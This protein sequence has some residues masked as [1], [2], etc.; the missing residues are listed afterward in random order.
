MTSKS[1][2][3]DATDQE[4]GPPSEEVSISMAGLS[5]GEREII[6][7]QL[8]APELTIGYFALFRY[9]NMN[10]AII[11]VIALAA[12]I[13]AGATMPLMTVRLLK[14]VSLS[15]KEVLE[16]F[17]YGE[18]RYMFKKRSGSSYC[19]FYSLASFHP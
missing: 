4:H 1:T 10:E 9:A 16:E 14:L 2:S 7:R 6:N 3:G 8:E 13:A 11:M 18:F 5:E 15:E 12:S 17:H 19:L